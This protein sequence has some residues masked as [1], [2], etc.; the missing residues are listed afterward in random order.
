MAGACGIRGAA[1]EA[2]RVMKFR[3]ILLT[4]GFTGATLLF[5][6]EATKL[7][8][9]TIF[10]EYGHKTIQYFETPSDNPVSR[11]DEQLDKGKTKLD[12]APDGLGYLPAVLQRLG[13]NVDS[14]VMVYSQSS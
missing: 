11:L 3:T 6:A 5:A 1:H 12:Y 7:M 4:A 8:E 13:L 2:F 14:Q 9:Q 10:V